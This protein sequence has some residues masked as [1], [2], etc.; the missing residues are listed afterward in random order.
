MAVDGRTAAEHNG[1][2][3]DGKLARDENEAA[4]VVEG[5]LAGGHA[6]WYRL[7]VDTR[8]EG[9]DLAQTP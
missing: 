2:Q 5:G 9:K 8:V 3:H 6:R 1:S 7:A 4:D